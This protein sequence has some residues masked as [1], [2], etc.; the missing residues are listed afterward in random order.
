MR[1]GGGRNRLA[2]GTGS[3]Q[4]KSP[5]GH[6]GQGLKE[7]REE[8]EEELVNAQIKVAFKSIANTCMILAQNSHQ[9][10]YSAGF[11]HQDFSGRGKSSENDTRKT[12]FL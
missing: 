7:W 10:F 9:M 5:S 2:P 6:G 4:V 11:M 8:L 3:S 12:N 1:Q